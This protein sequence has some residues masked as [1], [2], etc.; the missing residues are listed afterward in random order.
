MQDIEK[1]IAAL[2]REELNLL[3]KNVVKFDIAYTIQ[4]RKE[5]IR[6]YFQK[7]EK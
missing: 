2:E 4:K 5:G 3:I 6:G 1:D 7:R